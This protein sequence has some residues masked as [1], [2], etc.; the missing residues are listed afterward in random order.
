M[1]VI[2]LQFFKSLELSTYN[3]DEVMDYDQSVTKLDYV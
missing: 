1:C 2:M 3:S